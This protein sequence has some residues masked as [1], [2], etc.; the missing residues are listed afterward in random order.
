MNKFITA[1]FEHYQQLLIQSPAIA[2]YTVLKQNVTR[3]DGRIRVRAL[4]TDGGLLE[5]AEYIAV[6]EAQQTASHTYTFHWQNAQQQL[7][8]R[9]DNVNHFPTLP[10]TPHHIHQADETVIGNP[11]LPTL[12]TVLAEI[13]NSLA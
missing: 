3:R 4:L 6:I 12:E 13:E 2:R 1:R 10:Y 8:R 5:F 7:V 9:W 11:H